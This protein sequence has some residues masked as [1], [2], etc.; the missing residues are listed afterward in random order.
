MD[1]ISYLRLKKLE[2]IKTTAETPEPKTISRTARGNVRRPFLRRKSDGRSRR[3]R[4]ASGGN[5]R[6]RGDDMT[7]LNP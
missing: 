7:A 2:L 4:R 6:S 5:R 3:P 1:G